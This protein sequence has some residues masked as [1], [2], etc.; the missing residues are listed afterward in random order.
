MQMKDKRLVEVENIIHV[1]DE[2]F[3]ISLYVPDGQKVRL[4]DLEKY[5]RENIL[6]EN[7]ASINEFKRILYQKMKDETDQEKKQKLYQEYQDFKKS[8]TRIDGE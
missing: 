3:S 7:Q 2:L 1:L 4:N 5:I 8:V 6:K